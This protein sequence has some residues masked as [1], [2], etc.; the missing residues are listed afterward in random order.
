[1]PDLSFPILAQLAAC[2]GAR[3]A[4]FTYTAKE[5]GEVAQ[6]TLILGADMRDLY[7]R[8]IATVEA[9]LPTLS[10]LELQAAQEIL[11]SLAVSLSGGIGN[12]PAFTHSA[13]ARGEGN[14]TYIPVDGIPG[15]KIHRE[16]GELHVSGL[17][18]RKVIIREGTYKV[19]KSRPLTLAKR[20]IDR[21]LRRGTIRQFALPSVTSAALN[22]VTIDIGEVWRIPQE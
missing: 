17:S 5:S 9:M 15:V 10:G 2:R 8:D 22:G 14:E 6:H 12:N 1:M 19:V 4:R 13:D 18:Q 3:F 21:E 11:S 7:E 16:T 20:K